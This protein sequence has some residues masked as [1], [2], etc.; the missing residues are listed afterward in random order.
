[1]DG[2]EGKVEIKQ[3]SYMSEGEHLRKREWAPP[4][5]TKE[6]VAHVEVVS[7]IT[8]DLRNFHRQKFHGS[9]KSGE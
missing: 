2:K 9:L 3:A 4:L 1:V 7:R 8:K 6:I 5:G